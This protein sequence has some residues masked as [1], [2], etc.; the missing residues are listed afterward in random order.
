MKDRISA[1]LRA[2]A[3]QLAE[4]ALTLRDL[5]SRLRAAGIAPDWL[6]EVLTGQITRCAVASTHLTAAASRL[7]GPAGGGG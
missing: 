3:A 1:G 2:D 6:D 7:D 4:H 5:A